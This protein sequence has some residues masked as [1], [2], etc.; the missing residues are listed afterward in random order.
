LDVLTPYRCEMKNQVRH[1]FVTLAPC[2]LLP[3]REKHGEMPLSDQ[4]PL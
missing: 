2:R 4:L 3:A 1:A